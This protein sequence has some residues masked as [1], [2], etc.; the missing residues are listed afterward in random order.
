MAERPTI[1]CLGDLTA[2]GTRPRAELTA[3]DPSFGDVQGDARIWNRGAQAW[4]PLQGGV[5]TDPRLPAGDRWSFET[6]LRA[7][8]RARYPAEPVFFL[9]FAD[10]STLLQFGVKPSWDPHDSAGMYAGLIAQIVAAAN[11]A[12]AA[13]DTLRVVGVVSSIMTDD[14]RQPS[15]AREIHDV[16][17]NLI[18]SLRI[19]ITSDAATTAHCLPGTIVGAG[20]IPWVALAPHYHWD[21]PF[22]GFDLEEGVL[23]STRMR[24]EMLDEERDNVRVLRTHGYST[25][26]KGFSAAS[27]VALPAAIVEHLFPSVAPADTGH[28]IEDVVCV[29]GDSIAEGTGANDE[30][31][32]HLQRPQARVRIWNAY[33]AA[34][35]N[36]IRP[37]PAGAGDLQPL[38]VG[39]NNNASIPAYLS[40]T[41][42]PEPF[43]AELLQQTPGRFTLVKGSVPGTLAAS[44]RTPAPSWLIPPHVDRQIVHWDPSTRGQYAELFV[45]GW[46]R[47]ALSAIRAGGRRPRAR[48][49]LISLGS[50]DIIQNANY[51]DVGRCLKGLV[52][53]IRR[54]F[55]AAFVDTRDLKFSLGLPRTSLAKQLLGTEQA[56]QA[57]RADIAAL[58]ADDRAITTVDFDQFESFDDIHFSSASTRLWVQQAIETTKVLAPPT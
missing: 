13:G 15:L 21:A 37:G 17:L 29:F 58:T 42:G 16:Y 5:N 31:P 11:A 25:D 52:T 12:H 4:Q 34:S 1:L 49:C 48:L 56:M 26:Q 40:P 54:V 19:A 28:P 30:L 2:V 53:L 45:R 47:S 27:L 24:I 41:H 9:K 36:P 10:D 43:L 57:V 55:E 14:W 23:H 39:Q 38:H 32:I 8:L 33:L 20:Q 3:L 44:T 35:D 51:R 46:L 50:N 6:R 18:E 7:A 22:I